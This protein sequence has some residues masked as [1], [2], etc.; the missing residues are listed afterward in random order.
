VTRVNNTAQTK[1]YVFGHITILELIHF[2][3]ALQAY[4]IVEKTVQLANEDFDSIGVIFIGGLSQ[5][6][7]AIL[8]AEVHYSV[9]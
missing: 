4:L 7:K 6:F 3:D 9:C 8:I 5:E 1:G 2:S